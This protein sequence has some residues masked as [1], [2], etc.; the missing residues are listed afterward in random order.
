MATKTCSVDGCER[1]HLARGWCKLHYDRWRH[2]GGDPAIPLP[3]HGFQPGHPGRP[4]TTDYA[5]LFESKVDRSNPDGCHLWTGGVDRDGYGLFHV[6]G[7]Q[8]R[9]SRYALEQILG[10]L[11][12]DVLACHHCDN[13]PCVRGDHLFPGTAKDNVQDM[14]RKGRKR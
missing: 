1:P 4:R 9:A 8:V 7:R 6:K 13:P 11:P 2:R 5:A 14:I 3:P 10:P 12:L